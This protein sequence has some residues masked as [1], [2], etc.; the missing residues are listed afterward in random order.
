MHI[1]IKSEEFFNDNIKLSENEKDIVGRVCCNCKGTENIRYYSIFPVKLGGNNTLSNVYCLCYKCRS[2]MYFNL[3]EN[4][5]YSKLVKEG[6]QVARLNGKQIG[7]KKGTKL[8]VKKA[9]PAKEIIK[10]HNKDFGGKLTNEETWKL[11]GI[12][13]MTFYKY[14]KELIYEFN[15]EEIKII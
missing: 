2:L 9:A 11:A 4:I 13:K 15:E 6:M 8:N 3:I 14:K 12:S 1:R 7:Q 5:N 10:K